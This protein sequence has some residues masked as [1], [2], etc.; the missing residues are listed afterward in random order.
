MFYETLPENEGMLFVYSSPRIMSFWMYNT[1]I[2]L[3]LVF[4][5]DQ[6]TVTEWIESMQPGYGTVPTLLPR[7]VS[8]LEAQYAL[9]LNAGAIKKLGIKVG[10]SLEIPLTLLYSD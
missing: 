3:D 10:D 7:Y 1:R 4:F 9:E 8:Q 5:S 6:L 2:P